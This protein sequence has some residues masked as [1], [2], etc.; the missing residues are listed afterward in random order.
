VSL[1]YKW[2]ELPGSGSGIGTK[3]TDMTLTVELVQEQG[4]K[5]KSESWVMAEDAGT[6][7]MG[8]RSVWS[9]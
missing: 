3:G 4:W 6:M 2:H 1:T 5:L 9:Y 7:R 8:S